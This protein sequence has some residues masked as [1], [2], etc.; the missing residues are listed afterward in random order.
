M[1]DPSFVRNGFIVVALHQ[2]VEAISSNNAKANKWKLQQKSFLKI[3]RKRNLIKLNTEVYLIV[4]PHIFISYNI[5]LIRSDM[6]SEDSYSRLN[7]FGAE[8]LQMS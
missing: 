1:K 5:S 3:A 6:V 8:A 2:P 4:L 7:L